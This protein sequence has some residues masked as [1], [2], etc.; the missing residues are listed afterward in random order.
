MSGSL[1]YLL[2]PIPQIHTPNPKFRFPNTK[3]PKTL[4]P[5]QACPEVGGICPFLL[6]P[7]PT[8]N[9]PP[10]VGGFNIRNRSELTATQISRGASTPFFL[11]DYK[12]VSNPVSH[13][14]T[15]VSGTA[16][17]QSVTV[18]IGYTFGRMY[19]VGAS[20]CGPDVFA[21]DLTGSTVGLFSD[22]AGESPLRFSVTGTFA[23]VNCFLGKLFFIF[24]G[25]ML[26]NDPQFA[27]NGGLPTME[28]SVGNPPNIENYR[29]IYKS[30]TIFTSNPVSSA[31]YAA[32]C[33]THAPVITWT[34][35]TSGTCLTPPALTMPD[36]E[37]QSCTSR[38]LPG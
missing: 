37:V 9:L 25:E 6:S 1:L 32:T 11:Y 2:L 28:V 26:P 34:R 20:E 12:Y 33:P 30:R 4:K 3:N 7:N 16:Q 18:T 27:L 35:A 23:Q 21:T 19:V 8:Q 36:S 29:G 13:T 15:V 10:G 22:F 17:S 5:W 31:P 14:Y 38:S 24:K